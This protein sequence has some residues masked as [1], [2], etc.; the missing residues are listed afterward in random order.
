MTQEQFELLKQELCSRLSH[1]VKIRIAIPFLEESDYPTEVL[2]A[3]YLKTNTI[4]NSSSILIENVKPYLRPLEDMTESE[5]SWY[6]ALH[7]AL[8]YQENGEYDLDDFNELNDFLNRNHL[9]NRGL[10]EKGL[11]LVAPKDMYKN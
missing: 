3:I 2:S 8:T 4:N 7:N 5:R 1:G 11:A 6:N 10:I 9:D